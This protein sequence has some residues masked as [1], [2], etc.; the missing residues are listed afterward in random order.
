MAQPVSRTRILGAES[1][2]KTTLAR[3]LA[4]AFDTVWNPEY[5]RPYTQLGRPDGAPWTSWEFTHIARIQCW[6]EDAL[7]ELAHRVLFCDTDA[8]TTAIFHE[9]YLGEPATAFPELVARPYA[10]TIVCGL[11]VPWSHDGIREF[12]RQR[13]QMHDRFL[14][15]AAASGAPWLLVEGSLEER[16]DTAGQAVRQLLE[17]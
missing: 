13:R 10:L 8:L 9:L 14:E 2:G 12:D 4:H 16:I 5:G 3:E 11:D 17:A 6:Y 1:T 7:A 15:A